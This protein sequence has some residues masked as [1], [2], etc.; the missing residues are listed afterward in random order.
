MTK[1][2]VISGGLE[3][4]FYQLR[5]L[6]REE[7][8]PEAELDDLVHDVYLTLETRKLREKLADIRHLNSYLRAAVRNHKRDVA[9]RQK[10]E[11][12]RRVEY[13]ERRLTEIRATVSHGSYFEIDGEVTT[14][15]PE[16]NERIEAVRVAVER[17][18]REDQKLIRLYYFKGLTPDDIAVRLKVKKA[19]VLQ[20]L[21]RARKKLKTILVQGK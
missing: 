14:S 2:D 17:L 10:S 15:D 19:T 13:A 12:R 18:G 21:P 7:G 1:T 3:R 9:R 20:R 16:R 11:R 4:V 5:G 6:A 8:V